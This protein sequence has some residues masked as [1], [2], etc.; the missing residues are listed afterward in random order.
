MSAGVLSQHCKT[1]NLVMIFHWEI[2]EILDSVPSASSPQNPDTMSSE[3]DQTV[4]LSISASGVSSE[5]VPLHQVV[6]VP[7]PSE[8]VPPRAIPKLLSVGP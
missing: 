5:S 1:H 6:P 2:M 3:N 4:L 8:T 7:V